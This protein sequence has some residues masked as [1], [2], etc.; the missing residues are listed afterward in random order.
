M[1][2]EFHGTKPHCCCHYVCQVDFANKY[3]GG[4][5]LGNGLVQ[6]EIRFLICPEMIISRL[7]TEALGD[8]EC[9]IMKGNLLVMHVFCLF[10]KLGVIVT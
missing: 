8:D 9:L 5:V 7:F 3:V 2:F 10:F 1:W 4:G 6:E